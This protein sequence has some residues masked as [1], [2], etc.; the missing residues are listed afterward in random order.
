MRTLYTIIVLLA[1][2]SH[3]EGHAFLDHAD[4]RVGSVVAAPRAVAV[5]M[6]ENLEPAFSKLQ[7]FDAKGNEIDRHDVKVAGATMSVSMPPLSPGVYKAVW[8][9]V[10]IDTHRTTGTFTFT[11]K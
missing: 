7:V 5:W 8:K 11:V 2:F 3:A 10:A 9:V 4:P 1:L 6:T